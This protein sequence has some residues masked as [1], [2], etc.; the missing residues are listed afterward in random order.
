MK[1]QWFPGHMTK[2]LRDLEENI[3]KVDVVIYV[4][5]A[6]A[7][8]SC[9]NPEITKIVSRKPIIYILNKADMANRI[10]TAKWEKYL[11]KD[12]NIALSLDATKSST[13]QHISEAIKSCLHEK[14][15]KQKEKGFSYTLRACVVG[16]PNTG[17][18]TLINSVASDKLSKT[19][20]I[21]GVTRSSAWRKVDE[22]IE[23]LDNPGTLW[24]RLDNEITACN[25]AFIGS[26]SDLVLDTTDLAFAL[27]EKLIKIAPNELKQRYLLDSLDYETITIYEKICKK[28]GFIFK[29]GE[30]DYE[31]CG[32]AILDDFRKGRIGKITLD[33][34]K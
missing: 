22:H 30:F 19:G 16:V 12:N 11:S 18:S 32:K 15:E 21:A 5:D 27:I 9:I 25:L 28:R 26:I 14:I 34:C 20:N 29:R 4:L 13:K 31:R 17:K 10:Q 1:I 3:K 7:P 24:P 23:L 33:I 2:A 8:L 6:R